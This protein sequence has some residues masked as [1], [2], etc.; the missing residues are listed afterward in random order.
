MRDILSQLCRATGASACAL[1]LHMLPAGPFAR[2]EIGRPCACEPLV[3]RVEAA[4]SVVGTC[5]LCCA[6]RGPVSS[7]SA[8]AALQ[9]LL[10]SALTA[11]ISQRNAQTQLEFVASVLNS[12]D[13]ATLLVDWNGKLLFA[14]QRAA[15]LL[16]LDGADRGAAPAHELP[17]LLAVEIDTI[18]VSGAASQR[19]AVRSAEGLTWDINLV[20][21]AAPPPQGALV[22]TVRPIRIPGGNELHASLARFHVSRREAEV[23]AHVLRGLRPGEVAANMGISEHTVKDHLKHLHAKLS[24]RSRAQLLARLAVEGLIVT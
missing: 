2:Y 4:G 21:L 23:L 18:R 17:A 10:E 14:N 13:E 16:A 19:R 3:I 22:V 15:Q 20:A 6:G 9:P 7:P 12:S 1:S 11:L 24:V 8:L 5:S